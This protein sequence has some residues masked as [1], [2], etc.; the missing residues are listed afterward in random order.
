MR[1]PLTFSCGGDTLAAT[2]DPGVRATGLLIVTGGTQVRV[3]A[4]RGQALLAA[5][6]SRRGF[7]AFRFDRRGVGDSDGEDPGFL[8]SAPDIAAAAAAFR[9]HHP[10]LRRIVGFGLCD[11]ATALA[12]HH[13]AAEITGLLLA[14]PWMVE[15]QA[16][17][18]PPAAIR[19]H[20]RSSLASIEGWRKLLGGRV[21]L[22][23]L[24]RGLR[25]AGGKAKAELAR[26]VAAA[27]IGN[28]V[29]ITVLLARDDATA[30]AFAAEYARAPFAPLRARAECLMRETGS[31]GFANEGD[32]EW[33]ANAVIA[34][35]EKIDLVG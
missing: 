31:H 11:G 35:L 24:R 1:T 7:P 12:L 6:V 14:N 3:G 26:Q 34:A 10:Q 17:L 2:I 33:L 9:R 21:D 18:P 15:T 8:E 27:L 25:A 19:R 13:R 5:A 29:P 4:H 32:A 30:I 22:R 23:K 20:Y 28:E 16:G